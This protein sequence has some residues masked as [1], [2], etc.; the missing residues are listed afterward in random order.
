MLILT[1]LLVVQGLVGVAAIVQ[2]VISASKAGITFATLISDPTLRSGFYLI[3][4][5]AA[6][7]LILALAY[8]LVRRWT[9][10]LILLAEL[11]ALFFGIIYITSNLLDWYSIPVFVVLPVL[12]LVYMFADRS[13]RTSRKRAIA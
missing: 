12:I 8:W 2:T 4:I 7:S 13:V 1:L 10:W 6:L 9:F 11:V 5:A 3:M